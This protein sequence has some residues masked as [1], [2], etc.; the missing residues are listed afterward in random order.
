MTR[1]LLIYT[2]KSVHIRSTCVISVPF[3]PKFALINLNYMNEKF[4]S[5]IAAE[6]TEIET[7]GLSKKERIISSE[8][9]AEIIVTVSYTHLTLQTSDLV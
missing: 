8:Q 2:E 7:A 6:L 9:G 1:I 3:Y 5:R 4:V